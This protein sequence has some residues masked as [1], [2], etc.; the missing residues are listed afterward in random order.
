MKLHLKIRLILLLTLSYN[1]CVAQDNG[2]HHRKYWWYKS[3]LNNDFVKVG[4]GAGESLPFNQRNHY[5]NGF[6]G[7]DANGIT[8]VRS[9]LHVGDGTSTLGLYIAQL[10]TEYALL[11]KNFQ[12][13]DKVKHELFCALNAFDRL[14]YKAEDLEQSGVFRLNGFFIRDDIP[15]NFVFNNYQHFNYFNTWDGQNIMAG[16]GN[17]GNDPA[18]ST[19]DTDKGFHSKTEV[20]MY[21]TSSS[22][23]ARVD[24][25]SQTGLFRESQDQAYNM[26]LGLAFVNKFVPQ[27]VSDGTFPYTGETDIREQ[28]RQQAKRIID[29][30]RNPIDYNGNECNASAYD[31]LI[32]S[33]I[34]N[35]PINC[36]ELPHN[37]LPG[38]DDQ[39]ADARLFAYPL[40]ES[41]C[42]ITSNSN[43]APN[44]A[45][46][47]GTPVACPGSGYHNI[48][49][50]AG[51]F[52]L[53]N[54]LATTPIYN[55][56]NPA[57][58]MDNRVF[59][60]NL[61]AICNCVYGSV[62]DQLV[63][64]TITNLQASPIFGFLGNILGWI[65]K[66][67][68][69]IVT[70]LIP[71]F[72]T[73]ITSSAITTN[74]YRIEAPLDHAPIAHALLHGYQSYAHNPQYSFDYLLD[75]APCDGIYNFGI[76]NQSHYE[77]SSDNRLDHPNRRGT[78]A[79]G[80]ADDDPPKGEY[81]GI[82]FMLYHNL[83]YLFK[84]GPFGFNVNMTDLSDIYINQPTNLGCNNVNAYETITTENTNVTCTSP[85]VWRAGKTI[86]FGAGTSITGNGSSTSGPN[87]HAYIQKFDCSS[88]YGVYRVA[89]GDSSNQENNAINNDSYGQG[90]KYHTVN[91][92]ADNETSS[93]ETLLDENKVTENLITELPVEEDPI[94]KMMKASYL[95][96]SK[97][98]FIKPT[99]TIDNVKAYF[100]MDDDETGFIHVFDLNG[101]CIYIFENIKGSDT[102]LTIDFT[103][104]ATG[105]YLLKFTTTKGTTKTQKIIKQ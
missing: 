26:L 105:T 14:D 81:H 30:I 72:Y 100:T 73:N 39:G 67:I 35:N 29:Y 38:G 57:F 75:V 61:S 87:F 79:S 36:T 16:S 65:W 51:G 69:T 22:W 25:G 78:S 48:Y 44:I 33:W 19:A 103:N 32:N 70:I 54:Q 34:I 60:S 85:T 27:G 77:W 91:Y 4:L 56:Q 47:L 95:D 74:A 2:A 102:G 53:W 20:G 82:D 76:N 8:N 86:Y 43:S 49:S 13:T 101:K 55:P 17:P 3:R 12:N 96:Y 64:Q 99:V 23:S 50:T 5:G 1:F 71:G 80:G 42:Q 88:D 97:E 41:E 18:P 84:S 93:S 9:N 46:L 21:K 62:A 92:S 59:I 68:S 90:A 28:A 37:P 7:V 66:L 83:Y 104:Q 63:A 31:K 11:K 58:G 24:E 15:K 98:L 45:N 52:P 40:G 89:S 10:A 6:N 94:E